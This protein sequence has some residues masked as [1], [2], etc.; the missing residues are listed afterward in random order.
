MPK[1]P[2]AS[3]A[4]QV[5]VI[6]FSCGHVPVTITSVEVTA[7]VEQ[8]S[9]AEAEPVAAG[10]VLAAQSMVK[11]KGHVME[12]GALSSIVII[13]LHVLKFPHASVAFHVRVS[14]FR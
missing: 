10:K 14:V 11:F 9:V 8:L 5:R 6:T 1:L 12:G 3:V 13:W 2:H 7:N 4:F